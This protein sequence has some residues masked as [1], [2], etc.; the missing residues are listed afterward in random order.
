MGK[1]LRISLMLNFTPNTSGC[2]GLRMFDQTVESKTEGWKDNTFIQNND[3]YRSSLKNRTLT[4]LILTPQS[5]KS[6]VF[7]VKIHAFKWHFRNH[8]ES[9]YGQ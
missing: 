2:Y 3:I 1:I 8:L 5:F 4:E 9:K 7:L 6:D